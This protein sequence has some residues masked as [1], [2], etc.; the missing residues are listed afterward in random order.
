[1]IPFLD[2]KQINSRYKEDI[3]QAIQKV[4]NGGIYLNSEEVKSFERNYA[5][6]IG[7][8]YGVSCGN[9]LDALTLILLGYK[10]TGI[11][12]NGD[13]VIVPANTYIASIL[14]IV[15][16][17]LK[18]ILVE[19]TFETLQ[20][21]PKLIEQHISPKTKAIMIVHLYGRCAY[22]EMI[23][24]LAKKYNL[25]LI[26]DNAQGHGIQYNSIKSGNLGD[27]AGHSFYPT[28]NLGGL[29]DAGIVTTNDAQLAQTIR[30][31]ANYGS[32]SKNIFPL[33]G[34]NSRLDA[35]QAAVLNVKLKYLEK[36]N[37]RRREIAK[38]YFNEIKNDYISFP[39]IDID[40]TN[41][42]HIFPLFT[43][44]RDNL[45]KYLELNGVE[46]SIHYPI[47]P[48]RQ[49]GY[50]EFENLSLPVTE[51]IH[52]EE[53]SLPISPALKSHEISQKIKLINNWNPKI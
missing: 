1:M 12:N 43:E 33:K 35:L 20:I 25:K 24:K 13:E 2:L 50:R 5:S 46:T 52:N 45:K 16:T 42:F 38:I 6:Y 26:E 8:E 34:I 22:T 18:P 11:M 51:K 28:K 53:L 47:P 19:P 30:A 32:D 10:E 23:G 27:A 15:R 29:G 44:Y 31:L 36:E 37:N 7:T 17:G 14:S 3:D 39:N 49:P 48:H 41:V 9:G 40:C 21:N 4:V